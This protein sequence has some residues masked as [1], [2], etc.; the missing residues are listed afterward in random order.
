VC[1]QHCVHLG[2]MPGIDIIGRIAVAEQRCRQRVPELL[3]HLR[4]PDWATR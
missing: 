1:T 2:A 4:Y 3:A